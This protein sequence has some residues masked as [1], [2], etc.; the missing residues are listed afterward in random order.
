MD[1]DDTNIRDEQMPQAPNQPPSSAVDAELAELFGCDIR[2]IREDRHLQASDGHVGIRDRSS[3]VRLR[4]AL[5]VEV[6]D[7]F[8]VI[9]ML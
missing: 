1:I 4:D 3:F 5:E 6:G 9:E 2:D 8:G 7:P